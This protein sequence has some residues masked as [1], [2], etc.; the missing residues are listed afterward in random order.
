MKNLYFKK[1]P[2]ILPV[3]VGFMLMPSFLLAQNE[4]QIKSIQKKTNLNSLNLLK[5]TL[6]KT[7]PSFKELQKRAK[8]KGLEFS[9]HYKNNFF[10]LKSFDKKTGLPF[11]YTTYNVD[12]A[13]GT[14][15]N[16]LNS[17]G[18]IFNLDGE[19]MTV[20]EWD[21]GGTL[22]THQEFG[23]RVTQKDV[24]SSL[25]NH[26]NHVA[27]TMV[28]SGT[29]ENAKGMA[30][31]A[32]LNAYDW[33]NDDTEMIEATNAGALLSNHSYGFTSGWV[34]DGSIWRW[35]GM[36]EDTEYRHYGKYTSA[37]LSW[38]LISSQ[39][40]YYLIVKAAGN[41]RGMG[42]E[43]GTTHLVRILNPSTNQWEWQTSTKTRQ[44][45]GGQFGFDCVTHGAV[46]KNI[47]TVGAAEKIN[48][49][50]HYQNPNDV[51][52]ASFSAFGSVDDG[53]IKPDIAG[54]GTNMYS[55][56]ASGFAD[57]SSMSGTS[58]ASPNVTGSLLLL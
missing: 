36:D 49:I 25:S 37:D 30:P 38:D 22:T 44:K 57:Y 12:A 16:K 56:I 41:P 32:K 42:P 3:A 13:K 17:T 4:A 7:S 14:G 52:M 35:M 45:N 11:Y 58:M 6:K 19:G 55:P 27:G 39:A 53:R 5:N 18:G 48:N 9:G 10:Q 46:G 20:Y 23:N 54:I 28:A 31:K 29:E 15:T 43:P 26:A 21:G 50:N 51:N 1:R 8:E 2:R 33:D 34:T 40:P 47:L 24:P